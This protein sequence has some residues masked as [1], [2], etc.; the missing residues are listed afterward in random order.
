NSHFQHPDD[1]L[2]VDRGA[3]SGWEAMRGRLEEYLDWLYT[4]APEIRNLTASEMAGA[5]QR[6]YYLDVDQTVTQEEIILD[7]DNF[8]DEAFLFLRINGRL[9]EDPETC[10]SGGTLQDMGGGLYLVSASSDHVVIRRGTPETDNT[11]R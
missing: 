8:Q 5:V 6:Y 7:L 4:A 11:N 1:V 3:E 9:P 10:I 2:D